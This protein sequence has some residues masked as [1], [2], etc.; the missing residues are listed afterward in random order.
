MASAGEFHTTVTGIWEILILIT[1]A[2]QNFHLL[3]TK[4]I[5]L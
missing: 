2:Q 5:N 3:V 4:F 1:I